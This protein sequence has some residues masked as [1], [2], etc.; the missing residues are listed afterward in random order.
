MKFTITFFIGLIMS[1]ASV[2][3]AQNFQWAKSFGGVGWDTGESICLDSSGNLI[4]LGFVKATADVDPGAGTTLITPSGE[5]IVFIHKSDPDGNFLWA[6]SFGG[7]GGTYGRSICT[8]GSGNLYVTGYFEETVD[9]DPGTGIASRSSNGDYDIFVLKLDSV[10]N[11]IWVQTF[12]GTGRDSGRSITVDASGNVFSTGYFRET[13]DFDPGPGTYNYTSTGN[14]ATYVLK[15]NYSG[16]LVWVKKMDSYSNVTPSSIRLDES[17]SLYISGNYSGF[18]DFNPGAATFTLS[19]A[20]SS[21]IFVQKLDLQGNFIWAKSFGGTGY[22]QGEYITTSPDGI[23]YLTGN[24]EGQSNFGVGDEMITLASVGAR[25]VFVLKLDAD[26]DVLWARSFGG[27]IDDM[28]ASLSLDEEGRVYAIG[29]F[30]QS[31][32]FNLGINGNQ[33]LTSAG[34]FDIYL[35]KLDD[36]GDFLWVRSFG[37]ADQE[38]GKAI[39]FDADGSFYSV[40]SFSLTVDFDPG[41]EEVNLISNG[42]DDVFLLKLNNQPEVRGFVFEDLNANGIKEPGEIPVPSQIIVFGDDADNVVMTNMAGLFKA[43]VEEGNQVFSIQP[44]PYYSNTTPVSQNTFAQTGFIDT[45]Y[46]GISP[47]TQVNDLK[48]GIHPF[49]FP[50]PGFNRSYLISFQ[51][52]GTT[53]IND[54]ELK[55]LKAIEDSF[56]SASADYSISNDTI[57]WNLGTLS[58]FESGGYIVS[59]SLSSNASIGTMTYSQAWITSGFNDLTPENNTFE[60]YEL[61]SGSYDPNDKSVTPESSQIMDLVPLEYT[62]RFQNT[63]T[64]QADFVTI[65]DTLDP[66]LEINSIQMIAATHDYEFSIENRVASWFFNDIFLPDS[67]TDEPGSHGFVKFKVDRRADMQYGEQIPNSSSIYFDFNSPIITNTCF[68]SIETTVV[69]DQLNI[70]ESIIAFPNPCKGD[71]NLKLDRELNSVTMELI[72]LNGKVLNQ[73][74]FKKLSMASIELPKES[75]VYFLKLT[76]TDGYCLLKLIRD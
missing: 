5:S 57:I 60:I 30:Q 33:T 11:F 23:V 73:K 50:R 49:T 45:L 52:L 14:N 21:D 4:T 47:S 53:A 71:I 26:G 66:D 64:Y 63:G 74:Y 69:A 70:A 36:D 25:D 56:V 1:T 67:T 65:R 72:D 2:M 20:G 40:G 22:D 38:Y 19:P 55:F 62:I 3:K 9:F 37:S 46:F 68:F 44:I 41:S 24:F 12:G 59:E 31:A 17:S 6:V 75:G 43:S 18:V 54:V 42:L 10:G 61:V 13:V 35:L 32:V 58:P 27:A 7:S 34:E 8:D 16:S 51:N 76:S 39:L 29:S 15:L 48:V 28:A